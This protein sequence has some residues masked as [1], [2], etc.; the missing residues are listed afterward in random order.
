[1]LYRW[2]F[3]KSSVQVTVREGNTELPSNSLIVFGYDVTGKVT[4][5]SEPVSGVSIIIFGVSAIT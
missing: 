1:M 4:S 5:K 3:E 2:L